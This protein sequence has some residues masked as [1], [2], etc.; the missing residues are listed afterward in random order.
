MRRT[1]AMVAVAVAGILVTGCSHTK[2]IAK[3]TAAPPLIARPLVERELPGL[4]LN[5][6]QI[7]AAMGSNAMSVVKDQATMSDNSSTLAPPECL[8]LDDAG[9]VTIYA[10]SG[11]WAEH[12]QT[13]NDGDKLAHYLKQVVVLFPT[14]DKARE[15]F[16]A[17]AQQWSA[18]TQFTHVQSQTQWSVAPISNT[19]DVLSTSVTELNAAA[20]GRG[21]GRAIA[22]RNN[23]II[24]V[25][26]CSA[27]P[28][29]SAVKIVNQIAANVAARW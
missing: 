14:T 28:G 21:C 16:N 5:P 24:D 11:S 10:N 19:N 26:T 20:P 2:G 6:D 17:S 1:T 29:D 23:V 7:N 15:F 4:L 8:Q 3:P 25:N 12:E 27:D 9:E 18:C 13:L 22:L